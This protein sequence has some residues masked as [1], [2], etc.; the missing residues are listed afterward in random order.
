MDVLLNSIGTQLIKQGRHVTYLVDWNVLKPIV[1]KWSRNRDPDM[2]RVQD[3]LVH[4]SNGGYFPPH[5]HLAELDGEGLVCYDGNHRREA[6]NSIVNP[7]KVIIDVMTRASQEDVYRAFESINK[8]VQVPALYLDD[9]ISHNIKDN[10]LCIVRKY[11]SKYKQHVSSSARCHAPQFNRDRF[12]ENLY[13]IW[14]ALEGRMS[15]EQLEMSL[16]YLNHL[17]SQGRVCKQHSKYR[18][19]II[20][21]CKESGLWLFIDRDIPLDHVITATESFVHKSGQ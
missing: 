15:L 5:L 16:E 6:L 7:P 2:L 9:N 19:N 20:Q 10:L 18:D 11:E 1:K 14:S 12:V 17:Y 8:S 4:V 3:L 13:N 21:K